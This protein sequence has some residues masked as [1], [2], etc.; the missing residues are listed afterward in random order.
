MIKKLFFAGLFIG[1]IIPSFLIA[2][3]SGT[4]TIGGSNPDYVSFTQA[5]NALNSSG[6]N[7]AVVFN[8]A[9]GT[10]TERITINSISGTSATNTI[11][12]KS[13]NNDS[14]A[15]TLKYASDSLALN[16]H[17]VKLDGTDYITFKN[18][19]FERTGVKNY[20]SV[21]HISG[22]SDYVNFIG[23][24]IKN[25][26]PSTAVSYA[27]LIY[28]P[29]G[30][31]NVHP[32]HKYLYNKFINGGV[33]I[34]NFGGDANNIISGTEIRNNIFLNQG[35]YA[36]YLQYQNGPI[37]NEN[38]VSSNSTSTSYYAFNGNYCKNALRIQRNK[39]TLTRGVAVYLQQST[40]QSTT[41]LIT[42]NFISISGTS[43]KGF[44]YSNSGHHNIYYNSIRLNGTSSVGFYL[45][46]AQ[47]TA[48]RLVNNI[49]QVGSSSMSM[50]IINTNTPFSALDYNAY[51][52]PNGSMGKYKSTTVHSSL[53]AW[54]TATSME[55]NSLNTNPNFVSTTD[56]HINSSALAQ[57]GTFALTT[58]SVT[59]DIDGQ[60]RSVT[61][62]DIGADE[63]SIKDFMTTSVHVISPMCLGQK[64]T[65]S[66]DIKNNGTAPVSVVLPV[67]YQIASASSINAELANIQNLAAGA[68][69]THTFNT[70]L[71]ATSAGT[72][73]L[74]AWF[75]M[76]DDADHSNDTADMLP[77]INS[78]PTPSLP[79]DT[80]V[81]GGTSVVLD[82]GAGFDDYLW[83]DNSKNQTI[84]ID[85]SGIGFGGKWIAVAVTHGGCTT[86]DS[87]LVLF[88]DCTGIEDIEFSSQLSVY[89]N[90]SRD[91]VNISNTSLAIINRIDILSI[92][93]QLIQ[94]KNQGDMSKISL[95]NLPNGIYYIKIESNNGIAIKKLV[96]Q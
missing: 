76:P 29:N 34:Y 86:K 45:T 96:K 3:I 72:Y 50:E 44:Y 11:T 30:T 16:N 70:L 75:N 51:Y 80:T 94:S 25:G 57:Q 58:P 24:I 46:G 23:N 26:T 28:A 5:V 90:P 79:T 82:P 52:F 12:F 66:M 10:Y 14:T 89:P 64:Y 22:N 67:K 27:S 74:K 21:F 7:G 20:S 1:M 15:V 32:N 13:S 93:G 47:S 48:I 69:Y 71:N 63:F 88:A 38:E 33:G 9:P 41:G 36:M 95:S 4:K 35:K 81:C 55:A 17:V 2:Q 40:S 78:Y 43:S 83:F 84:T 91:M 61:T 59:I 54:Q 62:P 68:S 42:N 65:V 56:L 19:T 77:T 6:I 31:G 18:I 39:F 60:T 73:K 85:S 92:D 37:I 87:T 8:V 49:I 53:S